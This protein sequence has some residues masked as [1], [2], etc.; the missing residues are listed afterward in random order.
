MRF[1]ADFHIHSRFARACSKALTLP[2]IAAWAQLKG[3]DVISV[4]DFTHPAWFAEIEGHLEEAE[5]E[6]LYR[7]NADAQKESDAHRTAL[8]SRESGLVHFIFTTEVSCIYSRGGK[9]R[10]I[11]L[12]IFAPSLSCARAFSEELI[13]RGANIS[14][15]GRP[16]LGI[17]AQDIL[18]IALDIDPRFFIVPAHAWTPWFA[19]F[20]SKSGFDSIEEC[21]G[22]DAHHITAIETGLSS[23]PSM[24]WQLSHLNNIALIS[25]SDA[26]SLEKL[27]REATVFDEIPPAGGLS[28]ASLVRALQ[29]RQ[30]PLGL[31]L[32]S[33]IEFYPEEGMYHIDG[34]RECRFSCEPSRTKELR[35]ICPVCSRPLT[36]GVAHRVSDL[37][38]QSSVPPAGGVRGKGHRPFE[39]IV[40]LQEIIAQSFGVGVHSKKVQNKYFELINRLGTEFEILREIDIGAL[41]D[42][43]DAEIIRGIRNMREKKISITPGYDGV[44]GV[45][46]VIEKKKEEQKKLF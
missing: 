30:E 22:E 21:F 9:V 36:I 11:H 43:I 8:V 5:Y 16:I 1:I 23:D 34:H 27:G 13:K 25:S 44:Y 7:L 40:P 19:I 6:G 45:I 14:S 4:A 33:T 20:G 39:S 12:L 32:A 15:D 28:Y 24:N 41:R 37:S 35:G 42:V 17:D 2:R 18:R 29:P 3:I 38:D 31:R 10:R 46:T 26:H